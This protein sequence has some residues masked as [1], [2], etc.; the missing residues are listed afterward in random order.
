MNSMRLRRQVWLLLIP[1][2]A[3]S[4]DVTTTS[5]GPNGEYDLV[6]IDSVPL[7]KWRGP[8]ECF[9]VPAMSVQ[10]FGGNRWTSRDS[11]RPGSQCP[12]DVVRTHSGH[13]SLTGDTI[14]LFVDDTL[15]GVKGLIDR[16]LVRGD[17]ITYWGADLDAGNFVYVRVR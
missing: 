5:G 1:L 13:F 4:K 7:T 9:D 10:R 14:D 2:A 16:G 12:A 6:A 11:A 17:T 8:S 3:C 15:I